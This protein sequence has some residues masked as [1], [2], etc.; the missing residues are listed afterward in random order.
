MG[1]IPPAVKLPGKGI[2]GLAGSNE[3]VSPDKRSKVTGS[4]K[5]PSLRTEGAFELDGVRGSSQ[6]E[7]D[8]IHVLFT[9]SPDYS[10]LSETFVDLVQQLSAGIM[11][12]GNL[13]QHLLR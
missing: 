13:D 6:D 5:R 4:R 12:L 2:R 3:N 10:V 11:S 8:V 1:Y 7:S 9:I